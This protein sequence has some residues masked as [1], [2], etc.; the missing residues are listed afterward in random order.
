MSTERKT[1]NVSPETHEKLLGL[2]RHPRASMEEVVEE[3]LN[4]SNPKGA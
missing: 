4:T 3:L 2:K 1:L